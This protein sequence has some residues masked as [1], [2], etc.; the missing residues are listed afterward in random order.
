M[1]TP[2]ETTAS[3]TKIARPDLYN[4]ERDK[5]E[6]WILQFDLF[7]KFEDK[8]VDPTDRGCLMAS[9]L[10]GHAATWIKPYLRK[11][12]NA[13]DFDEDINKMFEDHETFKDHLRGQ[14]GIINEESRADRAI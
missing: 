11:Y 6:D 14:F 8:Q 10:R 1:S 4:G 3:R 2:T 9:Y 7:F 12:M 5:L 13:S